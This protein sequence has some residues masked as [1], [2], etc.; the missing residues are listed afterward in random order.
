MISKTTH[1]FMFLIVFMLTGCMDRSIPMSADTGRDL[2]DDF[3]LKITNEDDAGVKSLLATEPLLLNEPHPGREN[4]TPL[5]FAAMTG[6]ESIIRFLLEQ[7]A[8]PYAVDDEG[9]YAQDLAL[10]AG[11]SQTVMNLL[12]LQ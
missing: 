1:L 10:R 12:A 4:K 5:H 7:G 2:R 11:A 9:Q 6:N 8:D 3:A